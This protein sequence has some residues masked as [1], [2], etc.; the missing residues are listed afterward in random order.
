MHDV[1]IDHRKGA[2]RQLGGELALALQRVHAG[3]DHREG[4]I[5]LARANS[6]EV[7][8]GT[9][10]HL[11]CRLCVG[12]GFGQDIGEAAAKRIIHAAGAAR[13]DGE[14]PAR[15]RARFGARKAERG[16]AGR[17]R[18]AQSKAFRKSQ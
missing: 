15:L 6:L 5:R 7:V 8:D 12:Q 18:R 17:Q 9:A 2:N 4:D 13:H 14:L 11:G 10:G 1:R 16:Q 3:I